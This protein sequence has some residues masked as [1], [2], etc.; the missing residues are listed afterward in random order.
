MAAPVPCDEG[1]VFRSISAL[2]LSLEGW[3]V[4]VGEILSMCDSQAPVLL[5]DSINVKCTVWLALWTG[6]R[7]PRFVS[8]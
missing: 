3:A 7:T 8:L 1:F 6:S 5:W 4:G 2:R